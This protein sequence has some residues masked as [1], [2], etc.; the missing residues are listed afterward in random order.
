MEN[1]Q[2]IK[3]FKLSKDLLSKHVTSQ[4]KETKASESL[5]YIVIDEGKFGS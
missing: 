5:I 1:C 4:R 2:R 3:G